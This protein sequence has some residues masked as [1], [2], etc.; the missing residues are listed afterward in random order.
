MIDIHH[1]LLFGVDDGSP[2][3]ETSLAMA[4]QAAAEGVTHIVCT[5]HAD[6]TYSYDIGVIRERLT[7]LREHLAGEMELSLG[8]DFHLTAE[9]VF[10]AVSNPLRYSINGRG[11]LLIEFDNVSIPPQMEN[12][13]SML[14][15]AGYTLVVTHPERYAALLN[16]PELLAGWVRK[17]CLIQV[18]AGSLYGNFG[19]MAEAF[20]NELLRRHW[21]HF[22][23]TDAH[24]TT[25]RTPEM[26]KGY[27]YVAQQMGEETA[28]RL[29]ESNPRAAVEGRKL[30]AQPEPR[31]L[32]NSVPLNF[33]AKKFSH[34]PGE[35]KSS[36]HSEIDPD[37]SANGFWKRLLHR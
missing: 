13:I 33:T 1:H 26:K 16:Q 23:A 8:C 24:N 30:P 3:L 31:G 12:A 36:H 6:D 15:A 37:V 35:K 19:R 28:R 27:D 11:Y 2:D 20:S 14:Q 29:F 17:G 22:V 25:W 34:K 32:W 9:N 4:R 21:I 5:P 10:D 7:V 18:T